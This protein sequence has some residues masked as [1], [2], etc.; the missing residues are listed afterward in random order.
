MGKRIGY[1]RVSTVDQNTQRQLDGIKLDKVYTDRASGKDLDR[2][3]LAEVLRYVREG[4]TLVVHSM[5]RLARNAIDLL[6]TVED[7][8]GRGVTIE[9]IKEGQRYTGERKPEQVL[10]LQVLAAVAQFERAILKERQREGIAI[11]RAKGLYKG[12]RHRLSPEQADALRSKHR[13]GTTVVALA[14][15]YGVSRET[16][17]SYLRAA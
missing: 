1:V 4:D 17:Y 10:M 8:T 11:A 14:K 6:R 9:F 15:A 16:V 12:R 7:L 13:E 3:A 2:P 5:D